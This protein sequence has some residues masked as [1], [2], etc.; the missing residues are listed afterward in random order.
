MRRWVG[1]D[2][3]ASFRLK[4]K[5]KNGSLVVLAA[6]LAALGWNRLSRWAKL[7]INFREVLSILSNSIQSDLE[8]AFERILPHDMSILKLTGPRQR[9]SIPRGGQAGLSAL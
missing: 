2:E 9:L 5:T 6:Q 1:L 7:K 3:T 4:R 8:Q